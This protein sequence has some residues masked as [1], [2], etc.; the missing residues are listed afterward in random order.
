MKHI[1]ELEKTLSNFFDWH[2]PRLNCL[3]QILQALFAVR[4]VNLTQVA[5]AFQTGVKEESLY[6]R[7]CRF[8]TD[9]SFDMSTIVLL[10]LRLFPLDDKYIL[11]LDRTNWKWGKT[12]INILMLSDLRA[13]KL[14]FVQYR[15]RLHTNVC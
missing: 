1:S 4:T 14:F 9:F 12:P 15:R 8:F 2:K 3:V 7:I 6:R 10:V 11:T 13:M 5:A